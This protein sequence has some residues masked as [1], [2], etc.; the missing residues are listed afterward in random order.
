MT[1]A[2][3]RGSSLCRMRDSRS[4][5]VSSRAMTE[6]GLPIVDGAP[7]CPFVAFEDERD[8][9][10][11]APD[12]RHRCYA[13]ARP[14][15]R[16]LAHQEAYCLASAFP[17]CPTFQDWARRE[18]A[19]ARP[20]IEPD[21]RSVEAAPPASLALPPMDREG[22]HPPP[23]DTPPLAPPTRPRRDWTAPPPWADEHRDGPSPATWAEDEGQDEDDRDDREVVYGRGGAGLAGSAAYRLAGGRAADA[24]GH[25]DEP[26]D[27]G[28]AEDSWDQ[29]RQAP[30][31]SRRPGSTAPWHDAA[32]D[33]RG[34]ERGAPSREAAAASASVA[35][36]DREP[37]RRTS[38]R[39]TFG[40]AWDQG[41]RRDAYPG[42]RSRPSLPGIGGLS[43]IAV[44]AVALV[45]AAVALF[46]LPAFLGLGEDGGIGAGPTAS[47][48]AEPTPTPLPTPTPAP[49]PT[50]YV[51]ASGDTLSKIA[52]RFG[53]TLEQLLA[54]NPQ[55]TN[56]NKI[57]IGDEVNIPLP[58][59]QEVPGEV[60][61][62]P[63]P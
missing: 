21:R 51:V 40:P 56:P 27:G 35:A 63:E 57:A 11:L 25:D 54:A 31:S 36:G 38:P 62:S 10:A 50:V 18:A 37:V 33:R 52:A 14:A 24:G 61:E 23:A 9:R 26:D 45:L 8:S 49:T 53:I 43:R 2:H 3:D 47:P 29:P 13:E 46:F 19:A 39:E 12:H 1:L 44:G 15:P 48:T 30:Q 42:L 6:R 5:R 4:A 7:A 41:R 28:D 58:T 17:V 16:A 34:A 55:I 32:S 22:R 20:P 60:E 59:P